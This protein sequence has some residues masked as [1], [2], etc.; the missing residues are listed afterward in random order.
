MKCSGKKIKIVHFLNSKVRGG[1]ENHVLLLLKNI[2]RERFEPI[3]VCPTELAV[4]L[5][6]ELAEM[7]LR[8]F[9]LEVK[10]PFD[11][12]DMLRF[13]SFLRREKI[14]IVHAHLFN[15]SRASHFLAK[16]AGVPI[17]IE[18]NHVREAWRKGTLKTWY[19]IDRLFARFTDCIIA[20]S[21]AN[22]VYLSGVKGIA[23]GK[24]RVVQNGID[25]RAFDTDTASASSIRAGLG[26][27]KD[28][29][30]ISVVA[31]LEPQKGHIYLLEAIPE[32]V[33]RY[34]EV[35]FLL[36]G[37]GALGSELKAQAARLKIGRNL[38]FAGFR[39]DADKI[40]RASDIFLLPS[41]W[42]GL[43]LVAIEASAVGLPV[44]ATAVDGT[45]EVVKDG[46]TGLLIEPRNPV[47]IT[48][49]VLRLLDN[50][51]EARRMGGNG[52]GFVR[53]HFD[54][55]LQVKGT[56]AIYTE[57]ITGKSLG[58]LEG[59]ENTG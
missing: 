50:P 4:I 33:K 21:K 59:I 20:V 41:L 7:D 5:G 19:A 24:V 56:E 30:L 55:S 14:D 22:A 58:G 15:A 53:A 8:V 52:A 43:P 44:I 46:E 3:V 54:I 40:L 25:T 45:P 1:V 2:N 29:P 49:A 42:E 11:V 17:T 12:R 57:F 32:I 48:E 37:D 31:R 28:V 18:T 38:I 35:V 23:A 6:R 27:S 13:V 26:I 16:L 47:A 51:Q 39:S 36:A 34:P 10:S 9:E